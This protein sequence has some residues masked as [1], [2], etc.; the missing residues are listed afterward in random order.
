MLGETLSCSMR[1]DQQSVFFSMAKLPDEC[2]D[3]LCRSRG[4]GCHSANTLAALF[5]LRGLSL[6][7]FYFLAVAA[8]VAADESHFGANLG[9]ALGTDPVAATPSFDA[10]GVVVVAAGSLHLQILSQADRADF[11]PLRLSKLTSSPR[12]SLAAQTDARVRTTSC[13]RLL[14]PLSQLPHSANNNDKDD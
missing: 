9:P 8:A 5:L 14:L 10:L 6:G 2:R 4:F 11:S 3:K 1:V 7:Q 13:F 12:S